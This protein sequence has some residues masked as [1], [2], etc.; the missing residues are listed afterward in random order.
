MF[1]Y[2]YPLDSTWANAL[3]RPVHLRYDVL[4]AQVREVYF[5]YT[6]NVNIGLL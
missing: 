6:I 4:L 5:G 2:L 1:L 3:A